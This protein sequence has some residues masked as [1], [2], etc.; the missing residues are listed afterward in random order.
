MYHADDTNF[1]KLNVKPFHLYKFRTI[2][3]R[4]IESLVSQS[5]YFAKPDTLNDPFDCRIDLI[6]A[7][8]RAELNATGDRQK[9]LSSFLRVPEF[10]EVWKSALNTVGVCAF[11]RT[12]GD[13]LL[14]S[15]YADGHRGVC[16]EYK[17]QGGYL[18]TDEFNLTAVGNV[19]YLAEPLTEWLKS[20]PMN[21]DKFVEEL[22]HKYLKTKNP[23]WKHEQ[24]SR[25]IRRPHGIF[26]FNTHSDFL[27][28]VCFGLQTPKADIDLVTNLA[29]NYCGC[30]RFFQMVRDET[31]FGIVKKTL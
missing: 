14:W 24:E 21:L 15:H 27:S 16:L 13:V 11:S 20:A 9:F 3:K 10:F 4:L 31:E 7:I 2:N 30:A 17:F 29:R 8:E 6:A 22:L 28:E 19:D 23:A 26:K 18:L 25:L 1:A 12:N 5:L